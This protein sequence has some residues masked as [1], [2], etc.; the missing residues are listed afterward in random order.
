MVSYSIID[1]NVTIGEKAKIGVDKDPNAEIVV[2][3]RD[4]SVGN[5][6]VVSKGQNHEKDIK[7]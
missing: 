5:G 1:E 4:I 2:L 3:G 6:V 7:K